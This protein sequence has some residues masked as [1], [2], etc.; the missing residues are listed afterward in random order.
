M[1]PLYYIL[2]LGAAFVYAVASLLVKQALGNGIGAARTLFLSN[3]G[4]FLG[5][6]PFWLLFG[7]TPDWSLWWA[8]LVA[9]LAAYL[10]A[11]FSFLALK[12][13][14]VSVA[15]P[16]L[17]AKV[18]FVAL[19]ATLLLR[20]AVPLVWWIG[21]F[22]TA[23]AVYLLGSVEEGGNRRNMSLT[24]LMSLL[25]AFCFAMLDIIA[26]G[27]AKAFDYFSFLFFAQIV[28]GTGSLLLIPYFQAP[29]R[30]IP[31]KALVWLGAGTALLV[32]QYLAL[33]WTLATFGKA[34][35]ANILYGSRGLWSLVVIWA[36]GPF[37]G[38][39]ERNVP[40]AILL[41]RIIGATLILGAIIVV[42]TE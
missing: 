2:P 40:R 3:L 28:V 16:L 10:G 17:G 39:F 29:L 19:L 42:L 31:T 32:A 25:S 26:T 14:D 13:G 4:F 1:D 41:R 30:T 33:T 36:I 21:A 15:T 11:L 20:E 22:M 27:W 7:G 23:L 9:G 12:F 38:N 35:G 8:P 37:L 5:V 18:L 24:I 34:T 6:T